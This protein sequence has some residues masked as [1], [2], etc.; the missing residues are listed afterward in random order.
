M[1]TQKHKKTRKNNSQIFYRMGFVVF[2]VA[3]VIVVGFMIRGYIL[4][5][6][7]QEEFE[8]LS[9][10]TIE[11]ET[12]EETEED[13]LA[14]LGIE[15]PD[16]S[17]DWA[18]LKETNEDIYAW[19]YIPNT[20]V[21]YPILQHPTQD[22]YYLDYNLDHTK[23]YPGCIY[24]QGSYNTKDFT[25]F[26]TVLY[27][28]NMRNGTMFRTLHNFEDA[29]FFNEN[30]Y[31]FVYT[32]ERV[33]VYDIFAAYTFDD[34]HILYHFNN[35]SMNDRADYIEEVYNVRDMG[36]HYREGVEVTTESNILTLVTCIGSKP[37]HRYLVQGVLLNPA[38]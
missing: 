19:I 5:Q 26:N 25:D 31:V 38:E 3:F 32:P 7:A 16:K 18:A 21:D 14:T 11:T 2:A 17:L 24:S 27:G 35:D 22:S 37:N 23:G 36:A 10:Q 34:R 28:H 15:V 20:N 1:Q 29:T 9:N 6:K 12:E 30:R 4:E 13:I 8:N 33:Y